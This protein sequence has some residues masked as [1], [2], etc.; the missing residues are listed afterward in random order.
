MNLTHAGHQG[1]VKSR[2]RAK[3]SEW[4]IGLSSQLENL[5][6]NCPN[7]VEHRVNIKECFKKNEVPARSWHKVAKDLFKCENVWYVIITDNYSR[8]F[9][10]FPLEDLAPRSIILNFKETFARF[11][12]AEIVRTDNGPQF[13]SVFK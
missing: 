6:K 5:V 7:C 12:V 11:S 2:D 10:I 1:I 8:F 3:M 13:Q 4:W 9:E